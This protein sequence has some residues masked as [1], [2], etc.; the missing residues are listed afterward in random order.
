MLQER[1]AQM[2]KVFEEGHFCSFTGFNPVLQQQRVKGMKVFEEGH[3]CSLFS[4]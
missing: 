1:E 4:F 2:A 3:F